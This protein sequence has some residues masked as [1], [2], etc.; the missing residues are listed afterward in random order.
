[1]LRTISIACR[2]ALLTAVILG[3]GYPLAMTGLGQ[4]FFPDKTDGSLIRDARGRV[5]G[6]ALLAQA[7]TKP[8]YLQPR[9]SAA[10]EGYDAMASGGSNLGPSSAALRERV[11]AEITRLQ[12]ENPRARGPI[13]AELVTASASGLDPHLSPAGMLWQLP[14]I[15]QARGVAEERVRAVLMANVEDRWFGLLGQPTVNVL[16]ANLALDRQFGPAR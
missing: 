7:A 2:A 12:A 6:S 5:T 1:M 13:P 16:Q 8:H 3:V 10:G 4:M 14:R 15:A 9:P 11:K